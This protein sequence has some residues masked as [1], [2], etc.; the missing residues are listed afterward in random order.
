MH[1]NNFGVLRHAAALAV[2]A[3]HSIP[4]TYGTEVDELGMRATGQQM[5]VG[6]MA[7]FVFFILSG[8]LITESWQRNPSP[9]V[10]ARARL[11][12][13]LPGLALSVVGCTVAGLFLTT[14]PI[15]AYLTDPMTARFIWVNLSLTD[16]A[17]SLPGVF[18]THHPPAV[19]GSLWTLHYEAACYVLVAVLGVA[20]LLRRWV[21]LALLVCG[22]VAAK[23]W[24]GG[25]M[26]EFGASFVGGMAMALWRP[27]VRLWALL[28]CA[29][30]LGVTAMTG[31]FRLACATAGAYLVITAATGRPWRATP[32]DGADYSY[33]IYLWAFPVQQ[34]VFAWGVTHWALNIAISLPLVL[35]CAWVSWH[36]V[37]R[38]VLRAIR[39]LRSGPAGR[40]A[41]D[42]L[43]GA[44]G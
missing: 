29:A 26:V 37:E 28:L 31:G 38:P 8:Y 39:R 18:T 30:M 6:H 12:R 20:G 41:P 19:N 23:S 22:V 15:G 10:F 24:I 9:W 44:V 27:P 7:V 35:A 32:G 36:A 25:S 42:A 21:V 2:L 40:R 34:L 43:R 11:G 5:T 14:V 1:Q 17:G 16:F 4:L 13:L 33:G 3:S